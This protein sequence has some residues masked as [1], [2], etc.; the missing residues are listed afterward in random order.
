[1]ISATKATISALSGSTES[2]S[3]QELIDSIDDT[4][5]YQG[6]T[7]S[8]SLRDRLTLANLR[9][10]FVGHL[11]AEFES[12]FPPDDMKILRDLNTILNPALLPSDYEG[13][14]SHEEVELDRVLDFYGNLLNR[15]ELKHSFVQF[16]YLLNV[17]KQLSLQE[18]CKDIITKQSETFPGFA[19]MASILLTIPLTSVPCERG[20]SSQNRHISRYCSRRIV[21]NVQNR[22]MIHFSANQQDFESNEV[23]QKAVEKMSQ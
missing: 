6:I 22:M 10:T 3:V 19:N 7:L 16:K 13:I 4:D 23:I 15:E 14:I 8:C 21:K 11:L 18:I 20:F 1:M 17:N 9:R 2:P 12:R 5:T